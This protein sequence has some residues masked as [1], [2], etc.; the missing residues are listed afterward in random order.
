[1]VA[2]E[3]KS[4][5]PKARKHPSK[6]FMEPSSAEDTTAG[7]ALKSPNVQAKGSGLGEG[8]AKLN[9]TTKSSLSLLEFRARR[10]CEL[11]LLASKRF[12]AKVLL[13]SQI[14]GSSHKI[15]VLLPTHCIIMQV[16]LDAAQLC[17]CRA[18]ESE[19]KAPLSETDVADPML[20]NCCRNRSLPNL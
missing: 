14:M 3:P 13:A 2:L 7:Q 4:Y 1:M 8:A 6:P 9:A 19:V 12:D 18:S 16:Q 10:P 15:L 11:L 5:A 20:Y 17:C